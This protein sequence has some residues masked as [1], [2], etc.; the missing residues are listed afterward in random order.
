[1]RCTIHEGLQTCR[2]IFAN[3]LYWWLVLY[4]YN[5]CHGTTPSPTVYTYLALHLAEPPLAVGRVHA[6]LRLLRPPLPPR[7]ARRRRPRLPLLD[8]LLEA[9]KL[10]AHMRQRPHQMLDLR[11]LLVDE[12][13]LLASPPRRG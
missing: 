11:G 10:A 3:K 13:L 8:A 2:K 7:L 4:L 12:A 1:M 6:H 9:R 5:T